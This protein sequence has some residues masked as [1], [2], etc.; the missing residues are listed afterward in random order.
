MK[1]VTILFLVV[2]AFIILWAMIGYPISIILLGKIFKNKKNSKDY[3]MNPEVTIMVVA[4]NEEKVILEKM[5]NLLQVN[6]DKTKLK[7][8][9]SSDN[10]TD[11]TNEIVKGFIK[12][13][14]DWNIK[15]YEVHE[16]KGKTNAQNEA[17][18]L[19]G[20]E[21]LIMTDANSML[22]KDAVRELMAAFTESEIV[23]VTGALK[24]VNGDVNDISNSEKTYWDS[25][26]RTRQIESNIKTITAGNGALYACRNSY[27]VDFNPIE[28]HDSAM[29]IYYG[30][31]HKRAIA[32]HDAVAYE[33]A[34]ESSGDEF[35]RKVRMNRLILKHIVPDIRMMNVFS[36]G[37]FSYFYF[38][39]RTCRY[40][41]WLAH[42]L[43]LVLSGALMFDS[44][45]FAIIFGGQVLFYLLGAVKR[46]LKID[47]KLLNLCYYYTITLLA[48]WGGVYNILTGKAKPFW[49]KAESTR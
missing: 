37:W 7:I 3:A 16:R 43:V 34:G 8:L 5:E 42:L 1:S 38:G 11:N 32:N 6:Y 12:N 20:T 4:H 24:I 22:D 28:C 18:K 45:L 13:N 36:Y 26:L 49:E 23:Y 48:Q 35:G 21:F 31:K 40:L 44:L 19:V 30:L 25:D 27:Y 33:K 39:H 10:S 47:N 2:S 29:P 14:R 17:Q 15:L 9:V 46:I 41:L